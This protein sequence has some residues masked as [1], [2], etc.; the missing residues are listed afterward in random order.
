MTAWDGAP[1]AH[2][3]PGPQA[4][5]AAFATARRKLADALHQVEGVGDPEPGLASTAGRTGAD[6]DAHA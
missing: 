5:A 2:P 3:P 4:L 6:T 1:A